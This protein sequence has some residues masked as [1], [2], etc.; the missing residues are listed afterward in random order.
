MNRTQII[1]GLK[2]D[3]FRGLNGLALDDFSN[4]NIFVGAN[5]S[6]K[7]S[8]LEALKLSGSPNDVGQIVRLALQRAQVSAEA[9]KKNIVNYISS[10]FQKVTDE[11]DQQNYYHVKLSVDVKGQHHAYEVDGTIGEVVDSS[12]SSKRTFDI[13][14][15]TS[16][17]TGKTNYRSVQVINGEEAKFAPTE[18][19]IY[20]SLYLH[21]TINYYRSCSSLLA[22]YIVQEGKQEVLYIL[23]TF[24]QNIDD[25]SVVGEDIY[26]HNI[27][28]GSMPLF[29]Y[30]SGLQKA[31]FLT[32][33]IA[34][35][36]NGVILIDEIDNAIHVSAFEDVFR[37]FL[38][39]C[40][41]WNVQAFITTHSAEAIDAILKI[42]HKEHSQEDVLRVITLRKDPKTNTTR[43]KVRSGEEAYSDRSCFKAELRV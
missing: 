21:S 31:V 28:S 22:E 35:C 2:I 8:V 1:E 33:A 13:A 25:I 12:G 17:D 20:S 40:L 38:N 36:K 9:R 26:L 37:W 3:N 29:A 7:T 11:E 4:V 16:G 6:G 14:I 5:N 23:Q 42:A 18:K 19:P 24:D 34:Y 41:R 27:H 30:G 32:I 43:K 39:A 10:I 15:K